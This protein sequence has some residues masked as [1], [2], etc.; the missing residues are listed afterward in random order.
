MTGQ[1]LRELQKS[2]ESPG[3]DCGIAGG[4]LV[5]AG[6]GVCVGVEVGPGICVGGTG[7]FEGMN[8]GVALGSGVSDGALVTTAVGL[9]IE[10][11]ELA[12]NGVG[13][14]EVVAS[15]R[16]AGMNTTP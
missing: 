9:L 12:L 1:P 10:V 2:S 8:V 13:E 11:G 15:F 5:G 4:V 6:I 16:T 7:V 3:F 14:S